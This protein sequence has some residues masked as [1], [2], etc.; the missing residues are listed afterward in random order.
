M[1]VKKGV[2]INSKLKKMKIR[3]LLLFSLVILFS[4]AGCKKNEQLPKTA[5]LDLNIT[6]LQD[7]G[8]NYAYE[9]WIMVDGKPVSA[10][11]FKVDAN[12]KMSKS[13]FE[14]SRENVEKASAYIL[15]IEP[16]PDN[17]PKPS[18]VHILA[19]DFSGSTA[20]VSV[21]HKAALGNDFSASKGSYILATPTNGASSNELSGVWFL[22]PAAGPGAS[23][24]LPTLPDGWK[25]EGW[26]VVGGKPVTTGKFTSV[27]GADEFNGFSGTMA[28]PPFPGEDLLMN[29]P[30]GLTFPTDL[31]GGTIVISVEPSPDNSP[32]PFLLKPLVGKVPTDAKDHMSYNMGNN[33]A[34][35]NPKGTVKKS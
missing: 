26:A 5:M 12:G 21:A 2:G 28:G 3:N 27:T 33:A 9:G 15:T 16:S 19:G 10:G 24:T 22:D 23:L 35:T 32:N 6:G 4:V 20:S 25:Y 30:S 34:K 31:S 11:V 7:L 14:L 1:D 8:A 29:A 13:S 18:K 17:D